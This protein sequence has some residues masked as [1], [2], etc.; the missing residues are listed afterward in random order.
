MNWPEPE[1]LPSLTLTETVP[2]CATC[3]AVGPAH[4]SFTVLFKGFHVTV[5]VPLETLLRVALSPPVVFAVTERD[6]SLVQ[7]SEYSKVRAIS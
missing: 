2:D 5:P 3:A 7:A 4:Q 1:R 6:P